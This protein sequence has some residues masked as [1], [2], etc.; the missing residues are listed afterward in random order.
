M[1]RACQSTDAENSKAPYTATNVGSVKSSSLGSAQE[2][3]RSIPPKGEAKVTGEGG[4]AVD[5]SI[6]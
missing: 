1:D 6:K 2:I 5:A 3:S 4:T